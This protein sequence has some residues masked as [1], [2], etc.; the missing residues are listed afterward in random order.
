M[1]S[2]NS[3]IEWTESTINPIKVKLPDGTI[4]G[5]HCTKISEGCKNC[6]AE[7]INMRFGNKIPYDNSPVKFVLDE[8]IIDKVLHWKKPR[9]IFVQS[10]GDIFHEGISQKILD[11]LFEK[12]IYLERHTFLILTKRPQ[13]YTDR[14][15]NIQNI[16]FGITAENQRRADE[17]VPELLKIPAKVRFVS[18]EPMLE[19]IEI[20]HIDKV[21]WVIIG[22]ESGPGRRLCSKEWIRNLVCQ[23]RNAGVPCFVKQIHLP[24]IWSGIRVS[25]DMTEWP[26]DL[27]VQKYP[28]IKE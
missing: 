28:K 19:P 27:R 4:K 14:W 22:C 3:K 18:V 1:I 26:E 8:K 13:N 15:N 5:W 11:D 21:D 10:M 17:R 2:Y 24:G 7:R 16:W 23:C 25:K 12:M 6:Y 9:M 20:K